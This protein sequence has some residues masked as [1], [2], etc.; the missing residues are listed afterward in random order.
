MRY[1][2]CLRPGALPFHFRWRGVSL[3]SL[4]GWLTC[5]L[6]QASMKL[7]Q[8]SGMALPYNPNTTTPSPLPSG[9]VSCTMHLQ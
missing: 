2:G 5:A 1:F 4:Q 3:R 9:V 8:V 6:S 7:R